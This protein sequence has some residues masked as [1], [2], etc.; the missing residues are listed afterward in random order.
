MTKNIKC[1]VSVSAR[2]ITSLV[3]GIKDTLY[4]NV[5]MNDIDRKVFP[6]NIKIFF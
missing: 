6:W 2:R 4:A 1:I 3:Q 5:E